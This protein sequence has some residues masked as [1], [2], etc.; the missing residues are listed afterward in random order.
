MS[1]RDSDNFI[2][3][4]VLDNYSF[5]AERMKDELISMESGSVMAFYQSSAPTYWTRVSTGYNFNA[6]IRTYKEFLTGNLYAGSSDM[7]TVL[8]ARVV[9]VKAHSH[10]FDVANHSHASYASGNHSHSIKDPKH[11][12]P[13]SPGSPHSHKFKNGGG[14]AGGPETYTGVGVRGKN[15]LLMTGGARSVGT[16]RGSLPSSKTGLKMTS[17]GSA[18]G[19]SSA[20]KGGITVS[21]T[22]NDVATNFK[23]KYVDVILCRKD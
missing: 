1:I 12:H 22:A 2:V 10:G 6:T 17:S 9:P 21:N 23:V 18:S 5:T 15:A 4:R 3:N 19:N 14:P 7:T 13:V 8:N 20:T 16:T 11:S